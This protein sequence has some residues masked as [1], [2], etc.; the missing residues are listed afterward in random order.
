MAMKNPELDISALTCAK[1]MLTSRGLYNNS[2]DYICAM[3]L[4]AAERVT[5]HILSGEVCATRGTL[6]R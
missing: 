6:A 3:I 2:A 5:G 4:Q 1:D